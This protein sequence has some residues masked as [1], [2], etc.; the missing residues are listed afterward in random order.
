MSTTLWLEAAPLKIKACPPDLKYDTSSTVGEAKWEGARLF[1][2]DITLGLAEG[3]AAGKLR[4]RRTN[5]TPLQ[6]SRQGVENG[7]SITHRPQHGGVSHPYVQLALPA[8]VVHAADCAQQRSAC[9]TCHL[10]SASLA[11][12]TR[13]WHELRLTNPAATQYTNKNIGFHHGLV[14]CPMPVGH[15]TKA[16]PFEAKLCISLARG[17]C[18]VFGSLRQLRNKSD[19]Q[20]ASSSF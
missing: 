5:G 8:A 1:D 14:R 11:Q 2:R 18:N 6:R 17:R 16:T 4:F 13:A 20:L 15:A 19:L 7:A 10:L 9:R 12:H 3:R